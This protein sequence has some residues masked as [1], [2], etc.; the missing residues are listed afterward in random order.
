MQVAQRR[1]QSESVEAGSSRAL[2]VILWEWLAG[3]H[4]GHELRHSVPN[5]PETT[6]SDSLG[7][8]G[9]VTQMSLIPRDKAAAGD[10]CGGV[11]SRKGSRGGAER[12][13]DLGG[14][15]VEDA[16]LGAQ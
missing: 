2:V 4:V 5:A 8:D 10:G 1:M 12:R 7:Q 14:G 3:R 6:A 15:A 9:A 16:A 11:G 13:S